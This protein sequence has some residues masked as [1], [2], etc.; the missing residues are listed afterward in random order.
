V[1]GSI[2]LKFHD[3]NVDL[4][5]DPKLAIFSPPAPFTLS[6]IFFVSYIIMKISSNFYRRNI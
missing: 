2:Y 5:L 4:N 6:V 3:H 1:R